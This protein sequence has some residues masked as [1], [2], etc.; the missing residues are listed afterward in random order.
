MRVCTKKIQLAEVQL[1]KDPLDEEVKR[2][3]S[4]SQGKLAEVFQDSV[5]RNKHLSA[6]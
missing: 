3:L 6:S 4:D 5:E 2:I 1:Q